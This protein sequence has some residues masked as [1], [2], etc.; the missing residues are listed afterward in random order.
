M[1]TEKNRFTTSRGSRFFRLG[2]LSSA[3]GSSYLG[4]SV[5][6]VF[7]GAEGKAKSLI[8]THTKNALRVATTFGEL[9]GAVMKVGQMMSLQEDLLPPEMREILRGLQNQAPPVPF[10][11]MRP[12]LQAELGTEVESRFAEI[13]D[14]A[15]ASA[16][17]GQVH[18]AK[19]KD[20]REVVVKIQYPDVDQMVES[21]LK[22]LRMFVRSAF[23]LMPVKADIDKFFQEVR[24]RLTEELDYRL[25]L[26]NMLEFRELFK[27][28]DRFIIPVPLQELSSKRVLTS[29][30]QPGLS[31][32]QICTPEVPQSRR[33]AIGG[34][35]LDAVFM[36]FFDFH[37][38]Q[39]DPNLANFAFADDDRIIMYDFG[40][41]KR[42]PSTFVEG[43]RV[44][45]ADAMQ[46]KYGRLEKDLERIG[47]IDHSTRKLPL[48]VY[49]AY[50]DVGFRKWRRPGLFDFGTTRIHQQ[51]IE[52]NKQYWTKALDYDAP[53]DA[54]F[55]DRCVGGMYG[56]LR[57]LKASV[58]MHDL[59]TNYL[60]L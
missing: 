30:F 4:E 38:L 45:M 25:E 56:N 21:D 16:S 33:D 36:Q 47:Y 55:L 59:L 48:E 3:V 24:S 11:Q 5:K 7:L 52:L 13:S 60:K 37:A 9:K 28:D 41:V 50:A 14:Q 10:E 35:L 57:K 15:Y 46:A 1:P 34:A 53:A 23:S 12:L 51:V 19:L 49:R 39:S 44:L 2:R 42:F 6:G 26:Q 20:G 29:I 27:N 43:V 8:A 32:D 58:S 40:C 17:I 54:M 31:G 22:N 18:W